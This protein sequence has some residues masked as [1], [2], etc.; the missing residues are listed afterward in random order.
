MTSL[1]L[2]ILS[3]SVY[4]LL[5]LLHKLANLVIVI[6]EGLYYFIEAFLY[7]SMFIS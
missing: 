6:P 7:T 4:L 3:L 1:V 5:L 2:G